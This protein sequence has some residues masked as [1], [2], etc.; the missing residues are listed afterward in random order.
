MLCAIFSLIF[1]FHQLKRQ[2]RERRE[3]LYKK[4]VEDKESAVYERKKRLK[5]Y[6]D[7]WFL[8]AS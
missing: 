3:Y 5:E 7:G 1:T 4:S 6:I 8:I 2:V